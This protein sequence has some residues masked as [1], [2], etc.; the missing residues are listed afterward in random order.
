MSETIDGIPA[1]EDSG[2][3]FGELDAGL[4]AGATDW[5]FKGGEPVYLRIAGRLAPF[6]QPP[7][8]EGRLHALAM[9]A[10]GT[11]GRVPPD[12]DASFVHRG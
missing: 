4:R 2:D 8:A 1:P 3:L 12:T 6:A 9:E 7:Q 5:Q 11:A 10:L